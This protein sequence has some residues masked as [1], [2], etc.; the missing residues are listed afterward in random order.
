MGKYFIFVFLIFVTGNARSNDISTYIIVFDWKTKWQKVVHRASESY[1][2]KIKSSRI[3]HLSE[4]EQSK[5][6]KKLRLT[7]NDKLNWE[8]AGSKFAHNIVS[9]CG[10]GLLDKMVGFYSG[11]E[12]SSDERKKLAAS[13]AKCA[14]SGMDKSM[15]MIY[16]AFYDVA[17]EKSDNGEKKQ[18]QGEASI[19][20]KK[21][22]KSYKKSYMAARSH[23]AFA[24]S[25]SGSWA[26]KSNRT[27]KEHAVNN[28]L[29]YCRKNNKQNEKSHPCRVINIDGAWTNIYR[30]RIT[31]SSDQVTGE[32][33]LMKKQAL[34]SYRGSY[35]ETSSHKAFAQ[36]DTGAWSW[37]TSKLSR[38]EAMNSALL[39]CQKNNKKSEQT[40]PCRII[41]V[42]DDWIE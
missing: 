5:I 17:N 30:K 19:I 24:Q 29:A 37:K 8:A 18:V 28:A 40:Y 34:T 2:E 21:A 38:E 10:Q 31:P 42:N 3:N 39:S 36:S 4:S 9:S 33:L 15:D 27:S 14:K 35:R 41:N 23:K 20:R 6:I 1:I 26:W 25:E 32:W 16:T 11:I 12:Y 13:Y 7:L 22:L